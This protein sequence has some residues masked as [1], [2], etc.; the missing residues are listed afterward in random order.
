MNLIAFGKKYKRYFII[1]LLLIVSMLIVRFISSIDFATLKNYLYDMPG[2]FAGVILVS[3]LAY[4]SAAVAW[5]LCMGKERKRVRFWEIFMF[6][7][8]GEM[9]TI[10]NPT[11]VIAGETL[12]AVY[13]SKRGVSSTHTLS[14]ILLARILILLSGIF[15]ITISFIYLT[16]GQSGQRINLF[17]ILSTVAIMVLLGYLLAK[18]LL[19]RDLLFG[20]MTAS[21][22]AKTNWSFL[23]PKFEE[24]SFKVNKTLSDFYHKNRGKFIIAFLLSVIHWILG[25]M[26]F[27]IVLNTLGLNVSIVD[28]IAVEMGVILFKTAGSIV[29]GQIGIEEYGNKVMLDAIG[30]VSNEVWLVV[31]L[32]RRGRQLFWLGIAGIFALIIRAKN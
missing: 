20:R 9:L 17:Y 11:G 22:R 18:F 2:M 15:L 5:T 26:E 14:S 25:A 4:L 16:I 29:P 28:T 32:I 1:G 3:F 30:I 8:V 23:T 19:S 10:F 21:L 13:L 24:N 27:Y 31:S 7:H 12:K 6:K